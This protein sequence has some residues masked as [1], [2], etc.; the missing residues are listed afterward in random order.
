MTRSSDAPPPLCHV[1]D[2]S[3]PLDDPPS[4]IDELTRQLKTCSPADLRRAHRQHRRALEALTSGR[5]DGLSDDTRDALIGQLRTHLTAL[6]RARRA[7]EESSSA[8]ADFWTLLKGL[9]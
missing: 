3:L 2:G 1:T 6:N 8:E 5:Y 4:N 7:P 9:W